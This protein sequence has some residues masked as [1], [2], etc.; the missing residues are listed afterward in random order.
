MF[1]FFH[2]FVFAGLFIEN[3]PF[4]GVKDKKTGELGFVER[5]TSW[6]GP[7]SMLYIDNP[8]GVGFSFSEIGALR[9]NRA[10]YTRDLYEALVQFF[11]IFPEQ[12]K[13]DLY[14]G[15]QSY[16]G[17]YV[18]ALGS[19][20]HRENLRQQHAATRLKLTGIYLGSPFFAPEDS[21]VPLSKFLFSLGYISSATM[22]SNIQNVT[23]M[24]EDFHHNKTITLDDINDLFF[25][26]PESDSQNFVSDQCSQLYQPLNNALNNYAF[27]QAI[28]TGSKKF[29]V[30]S[31][32]SVASGLIN[33]IMVSSKEELTLLLNNYK[34]LIYNGVYDVVVNAPM[35]EAGLQTLTNWT[36]LTQY[37]QVH[38]TRYA[39]LLVDLKGNKSLF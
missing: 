39:C 29:N 12:Q 37:K 5:A 8:V 10:G 28:H 13:N 30:D 27:K 19:H 25:N 16:A 24:L 3:G 7:F 38:K 36:G 6:V 14:L 34:T 35:I 26:L 4:Q 9:K 1:I 2:L 15:G 17:K 23:K 18:P 31:F 20:I 21:S 22:E 11:Q 32:A 33:D